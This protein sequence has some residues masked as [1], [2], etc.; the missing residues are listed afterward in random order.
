MVLIPWKKKAQEVKSNATPSD[1]FLWLDCP[2]LP[3][4]GK[5]Y[6]K[7][8]TI[9]Y[10]GYTFGEMMKFAQFTGGNDKI[11]EMVLEGIK[12]S[13]PVENLTTPD[14]LFIGLSRRLASTEDATFT[15][16]FA[17]PKCDSTVSVLAKGSSLDFFDLEVSTRPLMETKQG[18]IRLRPLTIGDMKFLRAQGKES[19][20][21]SIW[22]RLS[23]IEP[24]ESAEKV[25][26]NL[27]AEEG[28]LLQELDTTLFHGV[29]PLQGTCSCGEVTDVD[30]EGGDVIVRPFLP[31]KRPS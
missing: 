6:P 31:P 15:I 26:Y 8:W 21:I 30:L 29:K 13:F 12:A 16:K 7:G 5:F 24:F 17:C 27:T 19:S 23:D 25:I 1:R 9:Q 11:V 3:S 4:G 18:T 28:K 22:A 14:F 10:R 2:S 20:N